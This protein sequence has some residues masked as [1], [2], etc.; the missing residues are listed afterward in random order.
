MGRERV[1]L[2]TFLFSVEFPRVVI[3]TKCYKW[4]KA[5]RES[6][7]GKINTLF[8]PV[9]RMCGDVCRREVSEVTFR[10]CRQP[11]WFRWVRAIPAREFS[12]TFLL[13]HQS[14]RISLHFSW[15]AMNISM[16]DGVFFFSNACLLP[17]ALE[18]GHNGLCKFETS[19]SLSNTGVSLSCCFNTI[20]LRSQSEYK[21]LAV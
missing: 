17:T 14:S 13:S 12:P 21:R 16:V 19:D 4:W 10:V 11:G 1:S 6:S 5:F 9:H 20:S 15:V 8:A 2:F 7:K 18:S 3:W